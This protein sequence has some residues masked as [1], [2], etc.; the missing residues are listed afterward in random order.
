M[1]TPCLRLMGLPSAISFWPREGRSPRSGAVEPSLRNPR[2]HQ[3]EDKAVRKL[4]Q[5][6][7]CRE[8]AGFLDLNHMAEMEFA[9]QE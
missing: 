3:I 4:Q 5:P 2:V 8:L 7:R 1:I 6:V 9:G